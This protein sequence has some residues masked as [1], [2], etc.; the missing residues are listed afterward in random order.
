MLSFPCLYLDVYGVFFSISICL[1]FCILLDLFGFFSQFDSDLETEGIG[2]R[3]VN[4]I[5]W[6]EIKRKIYL[7]LFITSS[8]F[9]RFELSFWLVEAGQNGFEYWTQMHGKFTIEPFEMIN[10][11]LFHCKILF[12]DIEQGLYICVI[13]FRFVCAVHYRL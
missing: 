8:C 11:E 2:K 3:A 6:I 10:R 1:F 9:K 5:H 4:T 7:C 13:Y 12:S